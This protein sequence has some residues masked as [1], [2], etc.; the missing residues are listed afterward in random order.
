MSVTTSTAVRGLVAPIYGPW[1]G[2]SLCLGMISVA[3]PLYLADVGL[4]YLPLSVVL[5]AAGVGSAVGGL[6]AGDGVARLGPRKM[7]ALGAAV[8]A[9]TT[10]AIAGTEDFVVL[11]ALQFAAGFGAIALRISG[12]TWIAT[13]VESGLRGRL[14]SAMGGTRRFGAFVGPFLAG[15]IVE[16]YG[17]APAFLIA[18]AV[19]AIGM[20]PLLLASSAQP[21]PQPDRLP[22]RQVL[23]RHWRLLLIATAGP[24][25]IMAAR[26]GRAVV[27]PL[28][29]DDL[30]LSPTAVGVLVSIS[31]GAD[32]LLFPVA[33]YLMDTFGRLTAIVPAFS[34]MGIGLIGLSM[35]GSG[36][37]VAIAGAVIGIGNGLSAGTMMT[38]GADLAPE[39]ST[40][41]FLAGFASLQDW[42]SILGPLVVGWAAT[43]IGLNASAS[44]LG[45]LIFIGLGL[46][47]RNVGETGSVRAGPA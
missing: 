40:G 20:L 21:A 1:M 45:V 14:L 43:A 2:M 22:L 15:V 16:R 46:I 17:F 13:T 10:A 29:G 28:I 37:T 39:D 44:V 19:A 35:A 42:G 18:G 32:L 30:G 4:S 41:Q 31:T 33:G 47:V 26:R 34:L 25:L 3:L 7:L 23:A 6:P 27:L 12:Q 8:I 36:T 9:V 11:L 38:L 24:I 5:T